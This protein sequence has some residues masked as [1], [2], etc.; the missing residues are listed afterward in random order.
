MFSFGEHTEQEDAPDDG[1][2]TTLVEG[3]EDNPDAE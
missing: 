2:K 3:I 1:L